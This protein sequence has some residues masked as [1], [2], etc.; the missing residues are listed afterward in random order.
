MINLSLDNSIFLVNPSSG[1]LSLKKKLNIISAI[2]SGTK[3]KII[4]SRSLEDASQI[5]KKNIK[6]KKIIEVL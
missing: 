6:N 3:A 2:I 1:K 5:A 4:V